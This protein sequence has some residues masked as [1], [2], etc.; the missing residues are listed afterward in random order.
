MKLLTTGEVALRV[1]VSPQTV[2]LWERRGLLR[3][4]HTATGRRVFDERQLE[5]FL[6]DRRKSPQRGAVTTLR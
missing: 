6:R 2:R 5:R 4:M 1:G 3:G